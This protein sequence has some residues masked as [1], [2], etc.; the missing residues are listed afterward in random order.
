M[1]A[2]IFDFLELFREEENK[3]LGYVQP[4]PVDLTQTCRSKKAFGWAQTIYI[5]KSWSETSETTLVC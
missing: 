4:R 1:E 3:S 2:T 5:E